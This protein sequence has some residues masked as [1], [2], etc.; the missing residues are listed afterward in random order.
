MIWVVS[1]LLGLA[2]RLHVLDL[3]VRD[4]SRRI[5]NRLRHAFFTFVVLRSTVALAEEFNFDTG[6]KRIPSK[7]SRYADILNPCFERC[8]AEADL[9]P[10]IRSLVVV[11]I[12]IGAPF[13]LCENFGGDVTGVK[14]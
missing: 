5:D 4:R 12:F 13:F 9:E 2:L 3:V 11:N 7:E 6:F 1:V 10:E 14:A 8:L